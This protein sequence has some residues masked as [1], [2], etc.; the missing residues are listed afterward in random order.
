MNILTGK[1]AVPFRLID[2]EGKQ[3]S[4]EDYNE[5]WLL[6]VFHRHLG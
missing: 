4:L 5:S 3:Y 6:L 2:S 1:Q